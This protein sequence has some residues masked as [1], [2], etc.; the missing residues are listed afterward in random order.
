MA[1]PGPKKGKGG[2]PR[3]P[4]S[5]VTGAYGYKRVSVGKKD[6][7]RVAEHRVKAGA[8]NKDG[9]KVIVHHVDGNKRNNAKSNLKT[10]KRTEHPKHH[11]HA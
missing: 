7:K 2:R 10:M 1:H 6:G 11:R 8:A 3:T 5:N 9:D 4:K